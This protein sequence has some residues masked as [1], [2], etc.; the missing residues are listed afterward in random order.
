MHDKRKAASRAWAAAA[1]IE[2]GSKKFARARQSDGEKKETL[3]IAELL[4]LAGTR[5]GPI[6]KNALNARAMCPFCFDRSFFLDIEVLA[7]VRL[8]HSLEA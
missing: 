8:A 7:V 4:L 3:F 1:A 5:S 2:I 6:Q